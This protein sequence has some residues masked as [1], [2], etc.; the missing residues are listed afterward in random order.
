MKQPTL[1]EIV[2][3]TKQT[4]AYKRAVEK[5]NETV[6][7]RFKRESKFWQALRSKKSF[8]RYD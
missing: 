8:T 2:E 1:A 4:A 3:A 7:E 5:D 6:I